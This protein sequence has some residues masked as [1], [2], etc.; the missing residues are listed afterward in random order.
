MTAAVACHPTRQRGRSDRHYR[1]CL[2]AVA[3]TGLV[4]TLACHPQR[5]LTGTERDAR[6]RI[7]IDLDRGID[8]HWAVGERLGQPPRRHQG[9]G[10]P[11][12]ARPRRENVTAPV[13]PMYACGPRAPRV[14]RP[15]RGQAN[16]QRLPR[17][18][19]EYAG[20]RCCCRNRARQRHGVT[21]ARK[22]PIVM[23]LLSGATRLHR[24]RARRRRRSLAGR[25][26]SAPSRI[27]L[28]NESVAVRWPATTHRVSHHPG[29]G[30]RLRPPRALSG[31]RRTLVIVR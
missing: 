15:R 6:F 9:Q 18:R 21:R 30:Q 31:R 3:S 2:D 1:I 25:H 7:R 17:R 26:K 19:G 13:P 22:R 27:A 14:R 23:R 5:A 28:R 4:Q 12:T 10:T 20:R 16:G 29:V 8:H 11:N 24:E